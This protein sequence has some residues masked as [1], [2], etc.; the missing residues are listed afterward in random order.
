MEILRIDTVR[1]TTG[2]G[3]DTARNHDWQGLE[4]F[5]PYWEKE[6]GTKSY[7]TRPEF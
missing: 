1:I 5:L 6:K 7:W 3:L 2:K 4:D